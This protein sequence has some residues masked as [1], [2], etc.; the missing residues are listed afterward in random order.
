[1]LASQRYRVTLQLIDAE[2][3]RSQQLSIPAVTQRIPCACRKYKLFDDYDIILALTRV[4][5][6]ALA[7]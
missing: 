1:M 3:L 5:S 4:V 7:L 6:A 2:Q